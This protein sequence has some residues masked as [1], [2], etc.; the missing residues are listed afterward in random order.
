MVL[1]KIRIRKQTL[2]RIKPFLWNGIRYYID[3][4][5]IV[6]DKN[7]NLKAQEL[8]NSGY[9]QIQQCTKDSGHKQMYVHRIMAYLFL[10]LVNKPYLCVNHKDGNRR[11]NNLDNLELVTYSYNIKDG[12]NRKYMTRLASSRIRKIM[13][14]IFEKYRRS[15]NNA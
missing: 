11:N 15:D 13:P 12:Y 3:T 6:Y 14:E 2:K 5:G 1:K 10:N 9:Y 8:S 7:F 4:Q